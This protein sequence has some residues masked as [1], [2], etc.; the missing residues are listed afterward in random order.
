VNLQSLE[1]GHKHQPAQLGWTTGA[2][3][4]SSPRLKG[5]LERMGL[6]WVGQNE[7]DSF[8]FGLL[9]SACLNLDSNNSKMSWGHPLLVTILYVQTIKI[10]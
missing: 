1:P 7:Q 6:Y 2:I 4:L 8:L 9:K 3:L 5:F 10:Q